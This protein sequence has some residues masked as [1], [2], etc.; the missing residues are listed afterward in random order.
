MGSIPT[1]LPALLPRLADRL[2]ASAAMLAF[3]RC[4]KPATGTPMSRR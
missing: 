2:E 4:R 3:G 1:S